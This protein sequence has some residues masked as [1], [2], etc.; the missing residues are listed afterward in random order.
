M[1]I[2][3]IVIILFLCFIVFNIL[4]I[5]HYT[6]IQNIILY[7]SR[8]YAIKIIHNLLLYMYKQHE[9]INTVNLHRSKINFKTLYFNAID[10]LEF[11][12]DCDLSLWILNSPSKKQKLRS[13]LFN[14]KLNFRRT[15]LYSLTKM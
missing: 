14:K 7:R 9:F 2:H 15:L 1:L 3:I 4:G 13:S 8:R 12:F 11:F 5:T 6:A 10:F